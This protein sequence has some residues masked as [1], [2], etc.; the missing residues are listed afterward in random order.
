MAANTPA[1]SGILITDSAYLLAAAGTVIFIGSAQWADV[2]RERL[3]VD[4]LRRLVVHIEI[5]WNLR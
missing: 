4:R 2:S 3:A 1:T 5:E